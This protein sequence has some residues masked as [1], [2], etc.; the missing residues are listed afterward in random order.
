MDLERIKAALREA[1]DTKCVLIG[2][3]TLD[4]VDGVFSQCFADQAAILIADDN[5]YAA[6]GSAVQQRLSAAGREVRDRIVFPGR[7][8]LYA[9]YDTVMELQARLRGVG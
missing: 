1:T 2:S 4:A 5:T 6:A 3:G 9:D 7:P 8:A